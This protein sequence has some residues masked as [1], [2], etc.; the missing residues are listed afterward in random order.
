MMVG[1]VLDITITVVL[2]HDISDRHRHHLVG[3]DHIPARDHSLDLLHAGEAHQRGVHRDA[4]D[5]RPAIVVTAAEAEVAP[6]TGLTNHLIGMTVTK[7]VT[8]APV[9]EAIGTR[10]LVI[11]RNSTGM[12][13]F[14]TKSRIEVQAD[15]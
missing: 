9:Q 6:R 12:I 14:P 15:V 2:D 4:A 3:A 5:A 1:S 13:G 8:E 11:G 7:D 10:F